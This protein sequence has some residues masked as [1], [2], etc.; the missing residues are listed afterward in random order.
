MDNNNAQT[1]AARTANVRPLFRKSKWSHFE[2]TTRHPDNKV[3]IQKASWYQK[4]NIVL[5]ALLNCNLFGIQTDTHVFEK[6]TSIFWNHS[7]K[8]VTLFRRHS[9]IVPHTTL[10]RI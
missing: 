3:I 7:K 8:S 1:C 2:I 4:A 5:A 6:R 9:P 10:N